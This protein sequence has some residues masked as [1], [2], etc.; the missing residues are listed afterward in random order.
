MCTWL[1]NDGML[2]RAFFEGRF[3]LHG[4]NFCMVLGVSLFFWTSGSAAF[5]GMGR[6][7]ILDTQT[8]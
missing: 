5:L 7:G 4:K 6:V 2:V 1:L 8:N 3:G